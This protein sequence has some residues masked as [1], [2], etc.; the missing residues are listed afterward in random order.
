MVHTHRV[1]QVVF[2]GGQGLRVP[3]IS[4]WIEPS[5]L[6]Q[7][8]CRQSCPCCVRA[9]AILTVSWGSMLLLL[10][11]NSKVPSQSSEQ[12]VHWMNCIMWFGL[13]IWRST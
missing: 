7:A 6:S 12:A 13:S 10:V 11:H 2:R 5:Q 4:A 3:L 8:A 9:R 1:N